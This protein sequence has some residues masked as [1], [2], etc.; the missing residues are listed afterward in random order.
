MNRIHVK[1]DHVS[2]RKILFCVFLRTAV[3][4]RTR[5]GKIRGINGRFFAGRFANIVASMAVVA[6]GGFQLSGQRGFL[7]NTILELDGGFRMA[8]LTGKKMVFGSPLDIV[9]AMAVRTGQ[10]HL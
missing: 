6:G 10:L 2:V 7:M 1:M 3:T 5:S 4:L 9:A 8:I